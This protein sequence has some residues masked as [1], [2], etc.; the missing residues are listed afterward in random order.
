[1]EKLLIFRKKPTNKLM[2]HVSTAHYLIKFR[3]KC[4]TVHEGIVDYCRI[5]QY[6]LHILDHNLLTN[7]WTGVDPEATPVESH[8]F[9]G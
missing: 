2:F 3:G 1:M 4:L 8:C 7:A 5:G 6:I 9:R